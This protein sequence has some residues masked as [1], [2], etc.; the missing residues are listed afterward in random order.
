MHTGGGGQD[1][2]GEQRGRQ[3]K[4]ADGQTGR[5]DGKGKGH[6]EGTRG[7]VDTALREALSG[8]G[9]MLASS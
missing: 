5:W 6:R 2:S 4:G 8:R 1:M 3:G 7:H 9:P